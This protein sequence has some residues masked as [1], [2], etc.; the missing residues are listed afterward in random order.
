MMKT[1]LVPLA[2]GVEEMEAVIVIDVL[3]RA[4]WN[5]ISAAI[6]NVPLI[7]A[8]RGVRLAAD[9]LW[10]DLNQA[11]ATLD[12]IVIPGGARGAQ[13]LC[14]HEGVLEC[15]RTVDRK[16]LMIGAICA[17]PLVLQA[18]GILRTRRYTC[19][20]GV[21]GE[22]TGARHETAKTVRDGQLIT[23]QGPGT[24][25]DFALTLIEAADG[26]AKADALR[27]QLVLLA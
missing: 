5:V 16:G 7:K 20:P 21:E 27:H 13:A 9:C 19:Y 10:Q 17:G 8:S 3:R 6:G 18:A 15:L 4:G 24:A 11:L 2:D 1:I 22:I 23:S 25:F 14:H 26:A 12:G